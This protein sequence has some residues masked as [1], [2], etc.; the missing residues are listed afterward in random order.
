MVMEKTFNYC[1]TKERIM[2]KRYILP[3]LLK[4]TNLRYEFSDINSYDR[5]DMLADFEVNG[6]Q[7]KCVFEAKCRQDIKEF[8]VKEGL[9]LEL[10][11]YRAI[12]KLYPDR[13][14]YYIM[15]L[16][17]DFYIFNINKLLTNYSNEIE[18]IQTLFKYLKCPK[19]SCT[20][21]KIYIQK[22]CILLPTS[23]NNNFVKR[24]TL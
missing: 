7:I 6:K 12:R 9:M 16:K 23:P 5:K 3:S 19:V 14:F 18:M 4:K 8:Y 2:L 11:K 1:E 24:G 21:N 20:E 15:F 17:D 10:E 22:P 13:I